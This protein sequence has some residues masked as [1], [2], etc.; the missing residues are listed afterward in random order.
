MNDRRSD[1]DKLLKQVQTEEKI[2]RRGKLR[3]FL[4]AAPGVGKTYAML[5]D[6]IE[7]KKQGKDV[8]IGI[9]ESHGREDIESL[10]REIERLP[11]QQVAHHSKTLYEFALDDAIKRRPQLIL[12]D[13]MAHTN[14]PGLRHAKRWQ[15]IRELLDS[16]ID[17]YTTLNV[18]H[19]ESLND[20][21]SRIVHAPIR[22]TVPDFMLDI[23]DS[24]ELIDLPTEEL[25][26]RLHEGKIY[27]PE[28]A[29]LA[30]K[31]FFLKGN[32]IALRELAL[33]A[34]A[35]RVGKQ[36]QI[37]RQ[38]RGIRH[39]W[40][41][42]EKIMVCVGPGVESLQ[43]IRNGKQLATS[44][45][46]EWVAVH[47]NAANHQESTT[48]HKNAIQHLRLAEQL[49]AETCQLT[50]LDIV[51]T[52]MQYARDQNITLILTWKAVRPRWKEFLK[53]QTANEIVRQS[54]EI[55]V[56]IMTGKPGDTAKISANIEKITTFKPFIMSAMILAAATLI[57]HLITPWAHPGIKG[58]IFLFATSLIA[59]YGKM[60]PV[61]VASLVAALI[62]AWDFSPAQSGTSLIYTLFAASLA[63]S[64]IIILLRRQVDSARFT[65]WQATSLHRLSR[66]LTGA[67]DVPQVLASGKKFLSALLES[68]ITF[69]LADDQIKLA[70]VSESG[71]EK[72]DQKEHDVLTWVFRMGQMAGLGT[73][74]LPMKE[75]L[76]LP[77]TAS[78]GTLGVLRIQPLQQ[79]RLFLP[80]QIHLLEASASQ[81]SLSIEVLKLREK[82]GKS[83]LDAGL[84]HNRIEFMQSV[85]RD[86]S[87]PI[88]TILAYTKILE[89]L[90]SR[91]DSHKIFTTAHAI[92]KETNKISR[93]VNNILQITWLDQGFC[94]PIRTSHSLKDLVTP[95]LTE[96]YNG[97]RLFRISIPDGL[98]DIEVEGEMLREVFLNLLDN[99]VR[100]SP[101]RESVAISAKSGG[102]V[103]TVCIRNMGP[104][105]P[106]DEINRIFDK[107]YQSRYEKNPFGLGL[108]LAICRKII[109]A[110]G[111]KIW[112][113]NLESKGSAFYFTLP[114]GKSGT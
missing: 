91:D 40:S 47:V 87:E 108:G 25:L 69:F 2:S 61:F 28:R 58:I 106:P 24:I 22:E 55:D 97:D 1:P 4:G 31:H 111:G 39:V 77:L 72:T 80:E 27:I 49:G 14:A 92:F 65:A 103:V 68:Q 30:A 23:A 38:D 18:Q 62:F 29:E 16:Q 35:Q 26:R 78:H 95:L 89:T 71:T 112:A 101:E 33:R 52:L 43:L 10:L 79:G 34:T 45:Q 21:V 19:I 70:E 104:E 44:L 51:N 13:E 110:H 37:Y 5:K 83:M 9:I 20:D 3:I 114:T 53:R 93:L 74:T 63:V 42:H 57:N 36:V 6:G 56:Y 15:D 102:D 12:M 94:E 82:A 107:Y 17:V 88:A 73:D 113:E 75:A 85:A 32:L 46:C 96:R 11:L 59:L 41:S 67:L 86:L 100:F 60:L 105:I 84:E 64:C 81:I 50:G 7:K 99:A 8:I 54:G 66:L 98:P 109:E 90:A 48:E 76:Y